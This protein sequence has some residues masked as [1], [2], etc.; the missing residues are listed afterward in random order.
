MA[1]RTSEQ[2]E[3]LRQERKE[4]ILDAALHVFAQDGYHASSVSQIASKA[5]ISKGLLYNYFESK[6]A[7]LVQ[8]MDELFD[9][10]MDLMKVV[11]DE[12]IDDERFEEIIRLSVQIPLEEPKKW[13]LYMAL[14]F[15]QDVSEILIKEMSVKMGPYIQGISNYFIGKG[16][17][18]PMAMMR[19]FSAVLD[20]VQMH[21]LLDPENFPAQQAQDYLIEQFVRK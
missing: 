13:K 19:I 18:D 12:V 21:C 1:P 14:A 17:E 6:E 20:G 4:E 11:P 5:N 3:L 8:L 2:Y 7:V 9:Y 15:Q 16:Y 10:A